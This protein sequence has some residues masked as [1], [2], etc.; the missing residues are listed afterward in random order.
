[1]LSVTKNKYSCTFGK[2]GAIHFPSNT[3]Y[4]IGN[5]G[6]N[7]GIIARI[8]KNKYIL[9]YGISTMKLKR[10]TMNATIFQAILVNLSRGE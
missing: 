8:R 5:T 4:G 9:L 6:T 3:K 1:M 10:G 7:S 2:P